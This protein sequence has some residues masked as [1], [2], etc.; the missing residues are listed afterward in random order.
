MQT[1]PT[2]SVFFAPRAEGSALTDEPQLPLSQGS[3][4]DSLPTSKV[5]RP[6]QPE[7]FYWTYTYTS[8]SLNFAL[9][10]L[11]RLN[12]GP[13]S[14]VFDPFLGSGTTLVASMICGSK[15]TGIDINPFATLLSRARIATEVVGAKVQRY[16]GSS[17]RAESAPPISE[18]NVLATEDLAHVSGVITRMCEH[19]NKSPEQLFETIL[20]DDTGDFDSEAVSLLCLAIGARSS[21]H[22]ERGS[23]PVWYRHVKDAVSDERPRLA[24]TAMR[25]AEIITR[26][27]QNS[28]P[29]RRR[30]QTIFNQDFLSDEP[31]DE[32]FD[33]CLTSPPYLNRLDYVVANLPELSVLQ[34][35]TPI[36]LTSLRRRMMGTTK[37]VNKSDYTVPIQW[38]GLCALSLQKIEAHRSRASKE[39]YYHTYYQYFANL[40]YFL[41]RLRAQMAPA[42]R[43]VVVLQDSFY[44]DLLVPTPEIAVEMLQALSFRT[45]ILRTTVVRQHMG[46]LSPLQASYAPQKTL[47]ESLV[48]FS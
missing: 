1:R 5:R 44:K 16:L 35:V 33:V 23:N 17:P 6:G 40:F 41:K 8:F 7:P 19:R 15:T 30:G 32:Q 21:A 34:M 36:N 47:R 11:Q 13:T 14:K 43:G 4:W 12:A 3:D 24:L 28:P 22:L 18:G 9:A 29:I 48:H 10:V 25:W 20:L 2:R 26:D 31:L 38:G 42:G 37:I 39:Y 46:Q 27:L 45:D